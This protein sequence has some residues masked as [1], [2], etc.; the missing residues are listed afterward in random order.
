M[1]N[2]PSNTELSHKPPEQIWP[3]ISICKSVLRLA[4]EASVKHSARVGHGDRKSGSQCTL[5][6]YILIISRD[7]LQY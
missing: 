3:I 4:K 5:I 6:D 7:N 2:T 1:P